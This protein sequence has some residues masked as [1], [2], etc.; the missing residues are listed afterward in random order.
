MGEELSS[1]FFLLFS[2]FIFENFSYKTKNKKKS[3]NTKVRGEGRLHWVKLHAKL[4]GGLL[5][6]GAL[7]LAAVSLQLGRLHPN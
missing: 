6:L 5:Q 3:P 7:A 4:Q 2:S 1:F